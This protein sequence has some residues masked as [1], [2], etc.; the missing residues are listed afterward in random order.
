MAS[1]DAEII[2]LKAYRARRA[3]ARGQVGRAASA[4]LPAQYQMAAMPLLMP[5]VFFVFW[6]TWV[7]SPQFADVPR[8]G[9]HGGV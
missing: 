8:R 3:V 1:R 5:V 4:Q 7:F 2:D 9:G 6:P